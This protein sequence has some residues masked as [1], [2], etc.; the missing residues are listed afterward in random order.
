MLKDTTKRKRTRAEMLNVKD[1]EERL[2][3]DRQTY[4]QETKRL[5]RE[6]DELQERLRRA[7]QSEIILDK[8]AKEGLIDQEG[9]PLMRW[10][11]ILNWVRH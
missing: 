5:R 11:D 6:K 1:E 2:K 9:N 8:L 10:D 4:L 7:R 3:E